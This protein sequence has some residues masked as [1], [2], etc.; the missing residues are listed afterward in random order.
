MRKTGELSRLFEID[1][2]TL[3]Y[4]VKTGL[5][6]AEITDSQYH[7]YSFSDSMSLAFIRYYRGLGFDSEEIMSLLTEDSNEEKLGR[8]DERERH[9]KEELK[10]LQLRMLLLENLKESLAF[11]G[12]NDGS[13]QEIKTDPYYFIPKREIP[14]GSVWKDLYKMVPSIEFASVYDE[15]SSRVEVPDLFGHSG[16]SMKESWIRQFELDLPGPCQY[17]PSE[18]KYLAAWTVDAADI[19]EQLS[20]KVRPLFGEGAQISLKNEFVMYIFP[21]RYKGGGGSFDCLCFFSPEQKK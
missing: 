6:K 4:Y 11:I 3:N 21:T 8:I 12:Q 10:V 16:L 5:I 17:Y 20:E 15:N 2:T 18:T 1:R 7:S 19:R 14:D 9:L 13:L